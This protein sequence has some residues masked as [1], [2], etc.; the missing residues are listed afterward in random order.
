MKRTIILTFIIICS[1][2][3]SAYADNKFYW[4]NGLSGGG[5][6]IDG[7]DGSILGTGDAC[8]VVLDAGSNDPKYYVYRLQASGATVSSPNVIAP[9]ANAGVKRWHLTGLI[10]P[11]FTV[12]DQT[13]NNYLM[14]TNNSA[15]S[16]TALKNELYPEGNIWKVN[17]NGIETSMGHFVAVPS[18]ATDACNPG[19]FSASATYLYICYGTNTWRR[20]AVATW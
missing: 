8:F 7:I 6:A 18:T 10:V 12:Q 14:I 3:T 15:R 16:P 19:Q 20:V 1:L 11:N 2:Y 17:S 4:A 5:D 9:S 13:D